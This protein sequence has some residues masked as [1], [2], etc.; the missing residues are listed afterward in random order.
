[1]PG[2][3]RS[4]GPIILKHIIKKVMN[5]PS[6]NYVSKALHHNGFYTHHDLMNM[7]EEYRETLD[8]VDESNKIIM[9]NK[10]YRMLVRISQSFFFHNNVDTSDF[11]NITAEQFLDF[12]DIY[13]P[14]APIT[15]STPVSTLSRRKNNRET[16]L[17]YIL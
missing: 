5:L 12:C 13:D 9:L 2:S 7:S 8:F 4:Q 1:M 16:V 11:I 14:N 6:D 17:G 10:G 15:P 3:T